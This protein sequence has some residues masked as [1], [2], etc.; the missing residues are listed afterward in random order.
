MSKDNI[1]K[2]SFRVRYAETDAMGVVYHTNYIVWFEVGRGE[3]MRQRGG[4]YAEVEREGC[5]FA[6]SEVYCR[7]VA[8]ARYGDLVTVRTWIEEV[9]SR[10]LTFVYEVVMAETGQTLVTGWTR[11]VC[12][13]R[14]GRVRAIPEWLRE[15]MQ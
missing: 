2:T 3:Y 12:V 15:K 5:F 13:D 11:H 8:P 4:D 1:V 7:Y 10:G 14:Q 6:V 9:K